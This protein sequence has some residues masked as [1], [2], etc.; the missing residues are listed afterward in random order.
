MH[1]K[2]FDQGPC[3]PSRATIPPSQIGMQTDIDG[4]I[5]SYREQMFDYN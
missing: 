4:E 5:T 1:K 3:N 2:S